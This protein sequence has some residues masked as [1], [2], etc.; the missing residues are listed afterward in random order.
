MIVL[1]EQIG[2]PELAAEIA[3]WYPGRVAILKELRSKSVI[4]D[5]AAEVLLRA[6]PSPTFVTIN[7]RHFWRVIR[8]D[9]RFAVVAIDLPLE[10]GDEIS[11]WLRQ[12]INLPEFKTKVS[13]MGIVALLRPTRI[14]FYRANREIERLDWRVK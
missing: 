7:V 11:N 12:F 5:D 3:T 9:A 10:R 2:S 4:K 1:D 6:A 13:R 8:A 14:E